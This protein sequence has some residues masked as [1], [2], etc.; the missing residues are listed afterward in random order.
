MYKLN[1]KN[2]SLG[3]VNCAYLTVRTFL[4]YSAIETI[5]EITSKTAK[6]D[7]KRFKIHT[8]NNTILFYHI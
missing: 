3:T 6:I 7:F 4:R 5:M 2:Y 8:S 1:Y